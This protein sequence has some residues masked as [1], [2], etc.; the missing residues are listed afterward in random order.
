[1]SPRIRSRMADSYSSLHYHV[2]FSTK[3]RL[4]LIPVEHEARVWDYLGGV[5]R[6]EGGTPVQ[7]GGIETHV[8][9]LFGCP[10]TVAPA[11]VIQRIKGVSSHWINANLPEVGKFAW[12]DGYA[13]FS[14]SRSALEKVSAYIADQREHHRVRGFEEEYRRLLDAHVVG[15][16]ERYVF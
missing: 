9:L 13:V 12:Q 11:K 6:A 2:V 3:Q 15:Y 16:D 8:H 10:P 5:V 7:I 1:M 14:V 4:P